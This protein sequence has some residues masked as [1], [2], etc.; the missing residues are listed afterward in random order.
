MRRI[1][2]IGL[3]SLVLGSCVAA[4]CGGENGPETDGTEPGQHAQASLSGRT[5]MPVY[6]VVATGVDEARASRLVDALR[7]DD[8]ALGDGVRTAGGAIRYLNAE[9]FQKLPFKPAAVR[10]PAAKDE[11]GRETAP[12]DHAIDFEA[13]NALEVVPDDAAIALVAAAFAEAGFAP[14]GE[15]SV[16]HT[17]FESYEKDGRPISRVAIDTQVGYE[18]RLGGVKVMG[19]GSKVQVVLDPEGE[20]AHVVIADRTLAEDGEVE[21]IPPEEADDLCAEVLGDKVVE[22]EHELVYYA[23]PLDLEVG[24]LVP[25][26]SCTGTIRAG[27]RLVNTKARFVPAIVDAPHAEIALDVKQG[28]VSAQATVSGG[29]A[30][31]TFEWSSS[32]RSFDRTTATPDRVEYS[33]WGRGGP[34]VSEALSLVVTDAD[35]LTVAVARSVDVVPAGPPPAPPPPPYEGGAPTGTIGAESVNACA[36][37]CNSA[38]NADGL[39]NRFGQS[40]IT[41]SFNWHEYDA[42]ASDF[43][44]PVYAA[45]A[46]G[47]NDTGYADAVDL[48]FFS[49]HGGPEAFGFCNANDSFM[50]NWQSKWGNTDLEWIVVSACDILNNYDFL[51]VDRWDQ[52]FDGL[53]MI[54]SYDTHT[55]DV[56]TEGSKLANYMI[57][58]SNPLTVKNAWV[59]AAKDVQPSTVRYGIMGVY[60]P[61]WINPN[62]DDYYWG[63]GPTSLD[64]RGIAI[65][66]YWRLTGSC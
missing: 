42:W 20:V 38:A 57:R 10:M 4:G 35:G 60:G 23:P 53:H 61:D 9:R 55:Y 24:R 2:R 26:Y 49:G 16:D 14:E 45:P 64:I 1:H 8:N 54:M 18:R 3:A 51:S 15:V 12:V 22:V 7:L 47:G 59:Q 50:T 43:R 40:G 25:H 41:A 32:T 58:S 44:D 13:L 11:N 63:I 29:R 28:T 66:G 33:V 36:D 31:Y 34:V 21:I 46:Y 6:R 56:S 39:V 5:T 48:V 52:A 17:Y 62:V 19:P 30:P 37:L 27:G 65:W